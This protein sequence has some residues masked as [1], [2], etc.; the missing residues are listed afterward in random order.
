VLIVRVHPE[1]LQS[2]SPPEQPSDEATLWEQR[3]RSILNLEQH[4][5]AN[6]TLVIK[7]FL[8]LSPEEQLKRFLARIDDPKKNWKFSAADIEERQFWPQY[9]QAYAQ[10][11]S[12]TSTAH[13][14]WY[15][16][17]AD[18]KRNARL[19]ISRIVIETLETLGMAYPK[20]T[21]SRHRELLAIRKLLAE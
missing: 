8:H 13:A 20:T 21:G 3:Y 7:F 15:T 4:L 16:V 19:I 10:C 11:L 6:G 5:H 14:P 12:A 17:P 18:D 1:L 2:Q 9:M